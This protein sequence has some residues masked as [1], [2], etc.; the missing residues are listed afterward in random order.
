MFAKIFDTD[1]GQLLIRLGYEDESPCIGL[2]W[3]EIDSLPFVILYF[4]DA[5]SA[6]L[7]FSELTEVTTLQLI[8]ECLNMVEEQDEGFSE[9]YGNVQKQIH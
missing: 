8:E 4:P 9:E 7:S 3:E 6:N 5:E 1:I 2:Y